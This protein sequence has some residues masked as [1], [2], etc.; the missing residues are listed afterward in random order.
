MKRDLEVLNANKDETEK[1]G[2]VFLLRGKS[3]LEVD[4]INSGD[5]GATAK[6]QITETGHTLCDKN[7]PIR[8]EGIKLPKP[9]LFMSVEP[10]SQ[11]DEEKIS[12]SLQRLSEEDPSFI[13]SR[14]TETKQLLIGGQGNMQLGII[15]NKLKNV[16]GVDVNMVDQKIPYRETIK[17]N[18]T[19]QGRHKKQT[20]GA[21]QFGDVHIRFEHSTEPFIFEEKVVGGSVPRNFIPAVEKGLREAIEKG[22]LAGYPVVNIKATL[23]DGSYHPVDSSEMAFKQAAHIAFKKGMETAQPILLEPVMRVT[24]FIPDDYMGDIM[25]DMNKR[26]GRILGIEPDEM[27]Y[28][29]VFAEAPEAEMFKYATDLRSMTQARGYFSMEFNRYEEVPMQL[30][31]KIVEEAKAE[32]NNH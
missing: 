29:K 18:V 4:H 13:V 9:C 21:G 12:A 10:K 19:V 16:F 25:G 24:I 8:Y 14:N 20:G 2:P 27:G 11:G 31:I 7:F 17:G 28:Q 6:L 23:L 1:I 5:I 3:Q 26:R 15:V 32:K 30:A 22:T